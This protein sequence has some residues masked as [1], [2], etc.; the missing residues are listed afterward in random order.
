MNRLVTL[1]ALGVSLLLGSPPGALSQEHDRMHD[2][3]ATHRESHEGTSEADLA[4]IRAVVDGYHVALSSGDR[5]TVESLLA[6][7]VVVME[8]GGSEDRAHYIEHHL[9]GDMAFAAAV[10]RT[11]GELDVQVMGD[12]AWVSSTSSTRGAYRGREVDSL[13]AELMV[14]ARQD[15]E[16]RIRAIHWSARPNRAGS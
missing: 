10:E 5:E 16:W 12:V 8:S 14:L 7:E 1:A 13:G 15:G 4:A 6:E 2:E 9:P 3:H 11:R